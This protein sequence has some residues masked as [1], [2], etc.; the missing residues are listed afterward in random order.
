MLGRLVLLLLQVVVGWFGATA[1]MGYIKLGQ[2]RLL[3]FAVVAAIVVF[4]VGVVAAQVL[5]EVPTP[6][7]STLSWSLII[8]LIAA[9]AWT[10]G[11]MYC[12][13][14]PGTWCGRRSMRCWPARSWAT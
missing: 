11:P 13:I 2:F 9:V 1:I 8:A 14:C 4:L 10:L 12:A 6:N 3:I 5:R 7:S